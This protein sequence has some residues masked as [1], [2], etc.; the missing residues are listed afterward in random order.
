MA[1]EHARKAKARAVYILE[2][3]QEDATNEFDP[4][5]RFRTGNPECI[6]YFVEPITLYK[7]KP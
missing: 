5:M 4:E 2:N 3:N 1:E 7:F 6:A